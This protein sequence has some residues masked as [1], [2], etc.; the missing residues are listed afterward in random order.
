MTHPSNGLRVAARLYIGAVAV[1]AVLF[2]VYY[3]SNPRLGWPSRDVGVIELAVAGLVA[4]SAGLLADIR[5]VVIPSTRMFEEG[6]EEWSVSSAVYIAG[7]LTY[8]PLFTVVT[9]GTAVFLSQLVRRGR[10]S[11]IA[12]NTGQYV[13]TIGASALILTHGISGDRS[14]DRFLRTPD[15]FLILAATLGA[16]FIINAGLVAGIV[17]LA[18]DVAFFGALVRLVRLSLAQYGTVLVIGL[19][20]AILWSVS[21]F[22][23]VLLAPPMVMVHVALKAIT[24]LKFETAQALLAIAEMV[25]ARDSYAGLHSREV[26]VLATRLATAMGLPSEDVETIKVAAQ[27]HDIGKMG[28]PD[29]VLHKPG[30][31]DAEERRVMQEHP[32]M[33]A[34]VLRYFSLFRVGADLALYHHEHYDGTGY[35]TGLAG[36]EI[37]LGARIIHVVDAYQ[38][39][40]SDRV[41]RKALDVDEAVRRLVAD[42]GKQFDP[43]VVKVFLEV[44][45]DMGAIAGREVPA[46]I[47]VASRAAGDH[48]GAADSGAAQWITPGRN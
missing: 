36:E 29:R 33:G 6:R 13:L 14:L 34:H 4:V 16:Y 10:L 15:A 24:Q 19:L 42:S 45:K 41:Y 21:P 40:T 47:L 22:S 3:A 23:I 1:A 25:D 5:N 43:Q 28:T 9:A 30:P 35:P 20:A 46:A 37:P 2:V 12:F 11:R 38:A 39:M 48:A 17:A 26:A 18:E 7:L 44:L 8:G 31:L 32:S 27:L